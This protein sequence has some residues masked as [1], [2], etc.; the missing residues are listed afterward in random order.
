MSHQPL[1]P[2]KSTETENI[3]STDAE[4]LCCLNHKSLAGGQMKPLVHLAIGC[5]TL[6]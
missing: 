6:V 5:V 4:V 1:E 3:K 2:L